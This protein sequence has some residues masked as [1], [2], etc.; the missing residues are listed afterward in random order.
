MMVQ[1]YPTPG[2]PLEAAIKRNQVHPCVRR[3]IKAVRAKEA[4]SAYV[5][6]SRSNWSAASTRTQSIK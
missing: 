2:A 5:L 4:R 1:G 3:L 6:R